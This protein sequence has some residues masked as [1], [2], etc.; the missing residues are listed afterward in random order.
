LLLGVLPGDAQPRFGG[1]QGE[2]G[3][4]DLGTQQHQYVLII[5]VGCQVGG[6]GRLY[7]PAEAAPKVQLPTYVIAHTVLPEMAVLRVT[8]TGL[9]AIQIQAVSAG[10]LQLRV[11][12]ALGNTQLGAGLHHPQTGNPQARIVGVGFGNQAVE[13][14]IGE[15]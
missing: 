7:G 4:C 9:V 3:F 11:A 12:S 2:I 6:V 8:A 14:R 10:L 1:A 13:D 5:G 15:N